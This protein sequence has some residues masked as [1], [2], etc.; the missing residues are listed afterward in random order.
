[1]R[2]MWN[3]E[4]SNIN[5]TRV[6]EGEKKEWDRSNILRATSQEFSKIQTTDLKVLWNPSSI[7]TKNR[8]IRMKIP[9]IKDK[10]S[11]RKKKYIFKGATKIP[12]ADVSTKAMEDRRYWHDIGKVLKRK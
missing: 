12:I 1:M 7:D 2:Y 10:S 4:S 8:Y 11:Q 5:A 3:S 9:R 6:S